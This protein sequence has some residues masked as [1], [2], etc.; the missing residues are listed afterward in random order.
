MLTIAT[1]TVV[2]GHIATVGTVVLNGRLE[3]NICCT[4]LEIGESGYLLGK[5]T[6][7]HVVIHG[8]VVGEIRAMMVE[9]SRNAI[10]EAEVYHARISLDQDAMMSGATL[11]IDR[12]DLPAAMRDVQKVIDAEEAE[13]STQR[14]DYDVRQA[15]LANA[16]ASEFEQLRAI[17]AKTH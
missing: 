8:Q 15:E 2:K 10:V 12:L 11:R 4:R 16:H 3:G 7:E 6:A 1:D 14:R 17:L 9:V 5:V 13:F